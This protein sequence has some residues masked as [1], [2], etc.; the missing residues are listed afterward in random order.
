MKLDFDNLRTDLVESFNSIVDKLDD[1]DFKECLTREDKKELQQ[2]MK[3]LRNSIAFIACLEDDV[4]NEYSALEIKIK[5][6]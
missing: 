6:F 5:S 2:Q 3:D 4:N 1:I